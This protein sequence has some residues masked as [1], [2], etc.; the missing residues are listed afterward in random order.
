MPVISGLEE[1]TDDQNLVYSALENKELA[2][3]SLSEI[4]GF[5]KNKVLELLETLIESGYVEKTGSGRGT[6]YT[7][8]SR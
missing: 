5:G 3:S 4:T 1:L 7:T 2:S 8:R 6:K